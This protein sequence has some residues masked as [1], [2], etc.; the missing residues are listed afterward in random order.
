MPQYRDRLPQLSNDRFLTYGGLETTLVH[1]DKVELPHFASFVLLE[2]EAWRAR[3]REYPQPYISIA[4][5]AGAGLI[6]GTVTWRANPEWGQRI[7]YSLS[8]LA[9]ANRRAV[10]L[11]EEVR[12]QSAHPAARMPISACVGP[13]GDGYRV[14]NQ[15]S[16]EEAADYHRWQIDVFRDSEADFV[17]GATL[18]YPSEAAGIALAARTAGL[19]AVISFTVETDGRLPDG[20]TLAEAITQVD[21]V[22]GYAPAYYMVNCAYPEHLQCAAQP[23]AKWVNR[24]RGFRAN[25]SKRSHDDLNDSKQLEQ[26]NPAELAADCL[27]LLDSFPAIN[28]LGGCCGTDHRHI[29][30]IGETWNARG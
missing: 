8:A 23:G 26:G 7:G 15:M 14:G 28:V 11:C 18:S 27:K 10:A 4:E 2:S 20:S 13:R 6:L 17:T 5:K 22:T 9:D 24:L 30:A 3:L 19:P 29:E 12:S 1:V 16:V 25:A 21:D